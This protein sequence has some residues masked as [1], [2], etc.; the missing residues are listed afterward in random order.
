MGAALARLSFASV[1]AAC[2][3]RSQSPRAPRRG[4]LCDGPLRRPS[5]IAASTCSRRRSP[6]PSRDRAT[7]RR[8]EGV[9]HA[10]Q[11]LFQ[12]ATRRFADARIGS[13]HARDQRAPGWILKRPFDE[14]IAANGDA[15]QR[16]GGRGASHLDQF[17]ER[18]DQVAGDGD[19]EGVHVLEVN[20]ERPLRELPPRARDHRW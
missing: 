6:P 11:I 14:G 2:C 1:V 19:G 9:E 13:R 7:G 8:R 20:I 12:T 10:R 18:M 4:R 15:K 16:V 3:F 17:V 5:P